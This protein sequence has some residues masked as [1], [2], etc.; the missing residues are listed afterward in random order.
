MIAA[1]GRLRVA[2][3]PHRMAPL[4]KPNFVARWVLLNYPSMSENAGNVSLRAARA[5]HPGIK[6]LKQI[7]QISR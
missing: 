2:K 6:D 7:T 3:L 1:A 4:V 5:R